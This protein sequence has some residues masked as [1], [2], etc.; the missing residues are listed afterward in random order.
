[1]RTRIALF[2]LCAGLVGWMALA[3]GEYKEYSPA[4]NPESVY[5]VSITNIS[6][7]S[8]TITNLESFMWYPARIDTVFRSAVTS[9]NT[10]DQVIVWTDVQETPYVV[11]T[12]EFDAVATNYVHSSTNVYTY[13]TNR[14][15][16][17]TN[18]A[19]A[20]AFATAENCYIQKGDLLIYT[21]SNTN[22]CLLKNT[23][24]R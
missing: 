9:T 3:G 6:G 4:Q 20:G 13:T 5:F 21:L 15:A 18:A 1:M 2:T 12:N 11:V 14:I 19:S 10:L 24:R 8:L 7:G 23:A 17:C 22:A 16:T